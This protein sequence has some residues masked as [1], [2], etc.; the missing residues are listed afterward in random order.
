[1]VVYLSHLALT[2]AR[3]STWLF[4][5]CVVFIP[6]ERAFAERPQQLFR[7][8]FAIDL[9]YYFLNGLMTAALL[10]AVAGLVATLLHPLVPDALL[11]ATATLPLPMRMLATLLVG[12]LGFYWGHRWSHE[13]PLLWRFHAVHHSAEQVD[14][15][16][17]TR[18]HPVDM[19]F[20][21]LC[22]F[23][24]IMLTGLA[25]P[26]TR[27]GTTSVAL[28]VVV[29]TLYGFFIHANLRWRFGWLEAVVATP[30]F[31]RWHHTNDA[32]RNHNYAATLPFYDWLF[33]TRHLPRADVPPCF[34]ID[35]PV[36][37]NVLSHL[38]DPFLL[39]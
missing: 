1:M 6:L 8:Q 27:A 31:H 13:I 24:L 28:L 35:R 37:H 30:A 14:W 9:A 17:N 21:R 32:N 2:T 4:L 7:R 34:G 16:T 11:A 12:E 22:G 39:R 15:L 5:L 23:V 29:T 38:M 25:Q 3:L 20:T 26:A 33:G 36:R 18:A 10:A 19:I